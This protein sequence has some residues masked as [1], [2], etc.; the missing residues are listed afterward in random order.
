M[1]PKMSLFVGSITAGGVGITLTAASHVIFA[2]LDW[3][4]GNVSQAED[5]LHR[6]G[7]KDSVLVQHLVLEDSLDAHMAKVIVR[8]QEVIEKALDKEAIAAPREKKSLVTMSNP[9]K[10]SSIEKAYKAPPK[11]NLTS[12]PTWYSS[13][14]V[15]EAL[16]I[17]AE[18]CDGARSLDGNGFNKF[19]TQFGKDLAS[20]N[21]LTPGQVEA[22]FKLVRKY[23]KQ[24]PDRVQEK[25]NLV[26][27][28]GV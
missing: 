15:L 11:K 20:R 21:F 28:A 22:G 26:Q 13:S 7:Q 4:P 6:I 8:K 5:R 12:A 3:V 17:L 25:L 24:L 1:N 18:R 2:E 16:K 9:S 10:E 27:K 23:R 14:D 19:D